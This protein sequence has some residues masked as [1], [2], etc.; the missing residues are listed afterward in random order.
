MMNTTYTVKR[1]RKR[2]KTISLQVSADAKIIVSAPCF[3]PAD[4]IRRFVG[5]K[6]GWI[7]KTVARQKKENAQRKDKDYETGEQFLYLGQFYPLEAFFEPFENAG[8][9]FWNDRF[10]LNCRRDK[11]LRKHYFVSWYKKKADALIRHRIDFFSRMLNLP[12]KRIRITCAESRWGSCSEDNRM[13]FSY[14]LI[15]APPDIIDYVIVHELM[16]I[17][18]KNHSSRFWQ[19]VEDVMPSYKAQ[20]RWL[21]DNHEKFVL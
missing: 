15:M 19:N 4:E 9:V 13:A 6:Q 16:H 21:K 11:A 18:E 17:R 3:T 7:D 10:Y 5:E 20:R 2:K 1:S 14:R 12:Y 8:I